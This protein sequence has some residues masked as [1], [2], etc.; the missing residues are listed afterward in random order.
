MKGELNL[1][2][3]LSFVWTKLTQWILPG[4]LQINCYSSS[5]YVEHLSGDYLK[6]P[7]GNSVQHKNDVIADIVFQEVRNLMKISIDDHFVDP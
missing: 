4:E 6:N 3:Q 7:S 5:L 2:K 1:H